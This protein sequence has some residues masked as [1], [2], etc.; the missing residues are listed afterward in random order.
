[1]NPVYVFTTG[2]EPIRLPLVE[3]IIK[4]NVKEKVTANICIK[5]N[6][7][8]YQDVLLTHFIFQLVIIADTMHVMDLIYDITLLTQEN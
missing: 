1:M 6:W 3:V 7:Y 5:L 8:P 4:R 2:V